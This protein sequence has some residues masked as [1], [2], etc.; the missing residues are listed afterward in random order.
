M[1]KG[2]KHTDNRG[3]K[4]TMQLC[5]RLVLSCAALALAACG[6]GSETG[7]VFEVVS[8]G[9]TSSTVVVY[10]YDFTNTISG[11]SYGSFCAVRGKFF[12]RPSGSQLLEEGLPSNVYV[13]L[14]EDVAVSIPLEQEYQVDRRVFSDD[15]SLPDDATSSDVCSSPVLKPVGAMDPSCTTSADP[16]A[17]ELVSFEVLDIDGQPLERQSTGQLRPRQDGDV[18]RYRFVSHQLGVVAVRS[19]MT[20][21]LGGAP[22]DLPS[23]DLFAIVSP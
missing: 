20:S 11:S 21:C 1:W 23:F 7:Q 6:S 15:E 8:P 4:V 2:R 10:R 19:W 13:S 5:P 22:E 12:G 16:E 9:V 18:E 3:T 14:A 17:N